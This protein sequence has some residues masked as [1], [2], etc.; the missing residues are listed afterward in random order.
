M[1]LNSY[2]SWKNTWQLH[3][4]F[5]PLRCQSIWVTVSYGLFFHD[6]IT[7]SRYMG[8]LASWR[9][10]SF[11]NMSSTSSTSAKF[12]TPLQA[13]PT[14]AKGEVFMD[15]RATCRDCAANSNWRWLLDYDIWWY[16]DD[17][18]RRLAIHSASNKSQN[19]VSSIFSHAVCKKKLPSCFALV[20]S[21]S[22]PG[23]TRV[24]E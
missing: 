6:L 5:H 18:M 7:K 24:S 15:M 16:C 2:L 19:F 11:I 4:Y 8:R 23:K 9:E 3:S 14:S 21:L 20:F 12:R 13:A 22:D 17:R 1:N 10:S